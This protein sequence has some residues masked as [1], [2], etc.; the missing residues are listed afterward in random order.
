MSNRKECIAAGIDPDV[1]ERL[2]RRQERLLKE[3][4]AAGVA[5]FCGSASSLRPAHVDVMLILASINEGYTDGGCGAAL[6][7]ADGLER[8]EDS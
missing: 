1:V 3:M 5:L 8:G 4:A 7:G 2:R 6:V